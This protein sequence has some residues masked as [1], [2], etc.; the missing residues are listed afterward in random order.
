[1]QPPAP[2]CNGCFRPCPWAPGESPQE[3]RE[4]CTSVASLNMRWLSNAQKEHV[5]TRACAQDS[6]RASTLGPAVPSGPRL[7]FGPWG[8]GGPTSPGMPW[9]PLS[10]VPPAG[11]CFPRGPMRPSKPRFPG[12]PLKPLS[13]VGPIGPRSP[14]G[15]R[16]PG[17]PGGPA[18]PCGPSSPFAPRRPRGPFGPGGPRSA[19]R[20]TTASGFGLPFLSTIAFS[21]LYSAFS[22]STAFLKI[23]S[24]SGTSSMGDPVLAPEVSG[25]YCHR[26]RTG[27]RHARA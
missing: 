8:P 17:G 19:T 22:C 9:F 16:S 7:P 21:S 3:H 13:P 2:T 10:P 27:Q 15:P 1:M 11:P 26:R 24:F 20:T 23:W 18:G 6:M 25:V 5:R 14:R 4:E 12:T